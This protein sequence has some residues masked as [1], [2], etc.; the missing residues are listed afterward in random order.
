MGKSPEFI[1][2]IEYWATSWKGELYTTNLENKLTKTL[3][4]GGWQGRVN[5]ADIDGDGIS[6]V[7]NDSKTYSEAYADD[8]VRE[9]VI[10][11]W[12]GKK[13]NNAGNKFYTGG[14][15]GMFFSEGQ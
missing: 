2:L 10:L 5:Y 8:Y 4:F 14:F 3:D 15:R 1:K 7:F 11:K 9:F 12:D 13:F 6:E